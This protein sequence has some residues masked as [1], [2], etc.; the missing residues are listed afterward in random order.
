MCLQL[1]EPLR[2]L[3]SVCTCSKNFST[4]AFNSCTT[5]FLKVHL[6]VFHVF[7]G[8]AKVWLVKIDCK[9]V[10]PA[11]PDY[12]DCSAIRMPHCS[13]L[14]NVCAYSRLHKELW[15]VKREVTGPRANLP[16]SLLPPQRWRIRCA[17]LY[18]VMYFTNEFC[19]GQHLLAVSTQQ[20]SHP[21]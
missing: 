19:C 16:A 9:V 14:R 11:V 12:A 3:P 7:G 17:Y 5:L 13:F 1:L 10:L 6:Y 15:G 21:A 18:R 20:R 8:R 2:L 4:Y